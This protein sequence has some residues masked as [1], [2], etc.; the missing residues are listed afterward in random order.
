MSFSEPLTATIL[1]FYEQFSRLTSIVS[2][3]YALD[4][5][6]ECCRKQNVENKMSKTKCRKQNVEN[7]MS[8][9]KYRNKNIET[10]ISKQKNLNK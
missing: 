4:V 6:L 5:T 10:K 8:K 2:I 1:V 9:T 7:K 3:T